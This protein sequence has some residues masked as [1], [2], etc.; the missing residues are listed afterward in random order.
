MD[1]T[2]EYRC[3][4]CDGALSFR[5]DTQQLTCPFCDS[6][7]D[8]A[9]VQAY[10][11]AIDNATLEG[12]KWETYTEDSGSGTWRAEE[13]EQ[14]VIHRC[15]ACHGEIMA[16]QNT[17]VTSCP[18]C[19]N[20]VFIPSQFAEAFRPDYVIP[21]QVDKEQAKSLL[22]GFYERKPLLHGCFKNENQLDEVKGIYV[23]FWLFD[24]DT[25]NEMFYKG[26][27]IRNYRDARF[28]YIETKHYAIERRGKGVFR[29]IPADG[30]SKMD[31]TFMEALE[32]YHYQDLKVFEPGYLAGFLADKYDVSVE[33]MEPRINERV[34]SSIEEAF[35]P[36]GYATVSSEGG[37]IKTEE[38]QVSYALLPVWVLN[39]RYQGELYTFMINGQ[40]GKIVGKLPVDWK[41]AVGLFF[42]VFLSVF[43]LS[44][45]II[46]QLL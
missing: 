1:T 26:T 14:L 28:E 13:S 44:S 33:A 23:P 19:D 35:R 30:S 9:G 16:D 45:L 27:R 12:V 17:A 15:S 42:G 6:E 38:S 34:R 10:Q 3:P 43:S 32:P 41:R 31:D 2:V 37:N 24:C 8:V 11:D 36:S 22:R 29:K 39:T 21:F 18:Y 25:D 4:H 5:S 20:H 7:L 46:S 40:T